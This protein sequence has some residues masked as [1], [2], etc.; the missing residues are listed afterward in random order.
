M[1]SASQHYVT[2]AE[3]L[4]LEQRSETRNEYINGCIFARSGASRAHNL[5]TL[6]L[7]GLLWSQLRGRGCEAYGSDMRVKVSPTGMYTYP[8]L[9][10]VCGEP[11]FEDPH[12]DTLLNPVAIIEVLSESTEAYDRGEKFAHYRRIES[13]R[14]YVLVAQDKMRVEH[15]RRDGEQWVLTEINDADGVLEL[16]SINCR[17][18]L[19][20]VYEKVDFDSATAR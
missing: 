15:Y 6:N 10:A 18:A 3:Y 20:D 19:R 1:S 5:I 14:E 4:D 8:D 11:R 17:I 12:I 9:V 13:L 16:S 2:P 7:S